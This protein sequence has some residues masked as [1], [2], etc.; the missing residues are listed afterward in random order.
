MDTGRQ[1][2]V[3]IEARRERGLQQMMEH[4]KGQ[5]TGNDWDRNG[6]LVLAVDG[7]LVNPERCGKALFFAFGGNQLHDVDRR[8]CTLQ[9]RLEEIAGATSHLCR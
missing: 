6:N 9:E 4:S 3:H 2:D 5:G 8:Q 7:L 1:G